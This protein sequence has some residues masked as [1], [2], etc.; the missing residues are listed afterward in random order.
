LSIKALS[1][2]AALARGGARP[3]PKAGQNPA[4][5]PAPKPEMTAQDKL[6]MLSSKWKTR[7]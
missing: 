7:T 3:A 4:P 6:A 2:G 1:G 5:K